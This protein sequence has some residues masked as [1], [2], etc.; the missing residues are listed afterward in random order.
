MNEKIL[1]IGAGGRLGSVLT[2]RLTGRLATLALERKDLDLG[3]QSAINESLRPLDFTHAV[4]TAALTAVDYCEGNSDEAFAV[5]AAAP[6]RIA[7]IA[8]EKGAHVTYIS[9]DMVFD[10]MKCGA[11][12][13]SDGTNPVSVY[14]ESKLEGERRVL[15]ASPDNLVARVSWVFGPNRPAFPEWI[16]QQALRKKDITL[17]DDKTGNPTFTMDLSEWLDALVFS[18]PESPAGGVY[19][20]CN[21]SPCTWRDWGQLCINTARDMGVPLMAGSIRGIPVASVDAFLAKR[22]LNSALCTDK[23][24]SATGIHPRPWQ[25]AIREHV[26]KIASTI[27]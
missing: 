16:I 17:P 3:S 1:I 25:E 22:P 8:A 13:E 23:F 11:Y 18:Q 24:T 2:T 20:L 10:G 6:G 21:S 12:V 4:I 26:I 27:S 7:E 5:N 14:G 9:T 15:A 19:H